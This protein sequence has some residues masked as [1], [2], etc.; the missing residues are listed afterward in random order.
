MNYQLNPQ[1]DTGIESVRKDFPILDQK[2]NGHPLI[3]LDNAATT[4]IPVAVLN[5]L[6]E[7]Y[8]TQNGN[9]HRGNHTLSQKSTAAFEHARANIARHLGVNADEVIFTSGTTAA[10]NS[11]ASSW[12]PEDSECN[13]LIVTALEHHSNFIPWQQRCIR[14]GWDFLVCPIDESGDIDINLL[15]CMLNEHRVGMVACAHVSNVLGTVNPIE[16]LSEVA[17]EHGSLLFV[18]AAQSIR[19]ENVDAS[20]LGCDFLSFSGHKMLA[21]TGIGV[22]CGKEEHLSKMSPFSFGGEMVDRVSSIETT[23]ADPPIRF[24]AGTPNYSGAIALSAAF[25]YLDEIGK[26]TVRERELHLLD[27]AQEKLACVP[28]VRILG[29][30]RERAGCLS[31]VVEGVHPFDIAALLD[32]LGVAVRSGN[33]CAQPLLNETFDDRFVVRISPA[34]YNSFTEIN[35]FISSLECVIQLLRG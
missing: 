34:F 35:A 32:S 30:P 31:F 3:Y 2:V 29:H 11:V 5:T 12:Q 19:H 1:D 21:P 26:D 33:L 20:K 28:L 7:H 23:F 27:Y 25:D 6:M 9:V 18:D 4:Q 8:Q 15:E 17:H 14:E 24:E 13:A 10:I 16:K 22:L